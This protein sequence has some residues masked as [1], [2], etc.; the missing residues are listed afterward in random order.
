MI[1]LKLINKLRNYIEDNEF[2][3]TVL[4][5][6]VDIINYEKIYEIE[7]DYITIKY[8]EG[9]ITIRGKNLVISKLMNDEVLITG[10][11]SNIELR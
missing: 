9:L 4:P 8:E 10:I 5:N 7:N 6:K 1:K 11:I 2:R 3:I